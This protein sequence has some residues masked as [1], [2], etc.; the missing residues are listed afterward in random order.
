MTPLEISI[1]LHYHTTVTDMPWV[2]SD[3]PVR[4]QVVNGLIENGLIE[5][6]GPGDKTI[7]VPTEKCRQ[8]ALMLCRTPLPQV[9]WIDPRT[10][11]VIP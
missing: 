11:I 9:A 2:L 5:R 7:Y 1:V 4:D 8:F 6:A 3:A 10:G